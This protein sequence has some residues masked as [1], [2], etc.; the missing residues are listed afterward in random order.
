MLALACGARVEEDGVES[1]SASAVDAAAA[2]KLDTMLRVLVER[3]DASGAVRRMPAGVVPTRVVSRGGI[4]TTEVDVLIQADVGALGKIR[5]VGADV[6][7]VT[8]SGIMTASI[9]LAKVTALASLSEVSRVEGAKKKRKMNTVAQ[10]LTTLANGDTIGLNNQRA[11]GGADVVVGV[12]DTGADWTHRD[13]IRDDSEGGAPAGYRTRIKYYWDQS[14]VADGNPPSDLGLGYGHEYTDTQLNAALANHDNSWDPATGTFG[15]VSDASY[16]IRPSARD[17]D[18]HGTHVAGSAA[19]DGSASGHPGGAPAADLV[20]VKFDFDGD[21][22]S[23]AAIIDG[24]RY[25]FERA[26]ALGKPA[27]I[28]MSLGSDYGPHDGSTLEERGLDDLAGPGRVV[29]VAAG[30]PGANDWSPNLS[31]G[32]PLHGEADIAS[33]TFSVRFPAYD[34]APPGGDTYVFFD[35]WYPAGNKCRIQVTTPGGETYPPSGKRYQNTWVTGSAYTGFNTS[36]GAILVQNGGDVLGWGDDNADHEAYIEISNYYNREPAQGTWTVSLVPAKTGDQCQGTLHAWYGASNNVIKGWRNESPRSPTPRFGGR[37]TDNRMTIGSPATANEAIAVAAYMSRDS[38]LYSN[39]SECLA[40]STMPQRYGEGALSYYDP[41]ALGE[42]AYFSGRGPRRDSTA[43][44]KPEISA[45]G[46]GIASSFSHF[47]RADQWSQRCVPYS[48]GGPYHYGTNRVLPGDEANI[49][50]GTSMATPTAT[51]GIALL[52]EA[53]KSM[54]AECLRQVLSTSARHDPATDTFANAAGGALTDTDTS[55]GPGKANSDWGYGKLDVASSLA[56][57]ATLPSCA[58]ACTTDADCASG[59]VCTASSQ[60][61]GCNT[62]A[63]A[64]PPPPPPPACAATGESCEA[65]SCCTGKCGGKPGSRT[66][67]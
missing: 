48:A 5:A 16:P 67:K 59:E 55:A 23:D 43:T 30:N 51:G 29:V 28:N 14:D 60:V 58:G 66:C 64:P 46:V 62:C 4:P 39:G 49:L 45:P 65:L 26:Q 18:G 3:Q 52:L 34:P 17:T 8:S 47:V 20:I 37:P 11:S 36:E 12:I 44:P 22:N 25:I 56:A 54:S 1:Q 31:W 41:F 21:R 42:L 63:S 57:I 7:T 61:C 10:G 50:Q 35:A 6:R 27:V 32:Y 2:G 38:W 40:Q 53:R 33:E 9:P 15:P 19:G 24:I 13:L